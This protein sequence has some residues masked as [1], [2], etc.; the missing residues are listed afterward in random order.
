[1]HKPANAKLSDSPG[2]RSD[3]RSEKRRAL[4]VR[5]KRLVRRSL[6][7]YRA[8]VKVSR[9]RCSSLVYRAEALEK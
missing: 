4:A 8:N 3:E 7:S 6:L 9:N 2:R 1:M 5:S